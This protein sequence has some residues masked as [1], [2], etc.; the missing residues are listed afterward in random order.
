MKT[1]RKLFP[2]NTAD[3]PAL[4]SWLEDLAQEGLFPLSFN[5]YYAKFREDVPQKMTYRIEV[6]KYYQAEP[7]KAMLETYEEFGWQFVCPMWK[8]YLFASAEECPI[9]PHTDPFVQSELFE[10]AYRDYRRELL[11][12]LGVILVFI[13]LFALTTWSQF[14]FFISSFS[15]AKCLITILVFS[16]G[17]GWSVWEMYTHSR[18]RRSLAAGVPLTHRKSYRKALWIRPFLVLLMLLV[19]F[20][21]TLSVLFDSVN[22]P[23]E[24]TS[25]EI[26]SPL[27]Y[28][29]LAEIEGMEGSGTADITYRRAVFAP[30]QYYIRE[31]GEHSFLDVTYMEVRPKLF[32]KKAMVTLADNGLDFWHNVLERQE[33]EMEPGLFDGIEYYHTGTK[34]I[35]A[36]YR[37]D[38][39]LRVEYHGSA[40]ISAHLP[41]FAALLEESYPAPAQ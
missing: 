21:P 35:F 20:S 25:N 16:L 27:P 6:P 12:C 17:I 18:L 22:K 37:G 31:N 19:G 2:G 41:A 33:I 13:L 8:Y 26:A 4:E 15:I 24:F 34:T 11:S 23:Q 32:A 30:V 40:D 1:K 29:S 5:G 7:P 10:E 3:I 38:A 39:V 9:E 14:A 36:A 28:L